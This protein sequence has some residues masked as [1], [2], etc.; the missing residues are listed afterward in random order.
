MGI[1]SNHSISSGGTGVAFGLRFAQVAMVIDDLDGGEIT[2]AGPVPT[3]TSTT[4]LCKVLDVWS[5]T[6]TKII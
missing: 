5:R 2:Y 4:S 6:L 3:N 1:K